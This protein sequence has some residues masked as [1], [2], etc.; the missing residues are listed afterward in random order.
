[1]AKKMTEKDRINYKIERI[2][3]EMS[4]DELNNLYEQFSS[5]DDYVNY[6]V[7]NIE[8]THERYLITIMNDEMKS[9]IK[10]SQEDT[11]YGFMPVKDALE[12]ITTYIDEGKCNGK[13]KAVMQNGYSKKSVDKYKEL[14]EQEAREGKVVTEFTKPS[15]DDIMDNIYMNDY[16][17]TTYHNKD[18]DLPDELRED[19]GVIIPGLIENKEEYFEF[20]RRLKDRGKE[21]LG[22][23]IYNKY[24]DYEEAVELIEQ[25]K[26][27][28]FDKYGGKEEFFQAKELGGM[29]GAYEYYP[30]VKPRFKKTA[31][32]IK[33]DKGI[34]LNSLAL[35][36]DMGRRIREEYEEEINQ[37]EVDHEYVIYENT[38]P[39]FKDL[40][41]ELQ[42]FYKTDKYGI[43]GFTH[44]NK[45]KSLYEYAHELTR[46]DDPE[47][48]AEG[49]RIID[50][51]EREEYANLDTYKSEFVDIVDVDELSTFAALSQFQYDKL[52]KEHKYKM[53][54]VD[55]LVDTIEVEKGY[56][57]FAK[58]QIQLI[59][60]QKEESY[61]TDNDL[62]EKVEHARRYIFDERYR[63][64][65]DELDKLN[66]AGDILIEKEKHEKKAKGEHTFGSGRKEGDSLI[67]HYVNELIKSTSST[68]NA[69]YSNADNVN[70]TTSYVDT[71]ECGYGSLSIDGSMLDLE[72]TPEQLLKYMK[73]NELLAKRVY[74]EGSDKKVGQTFSE[75]TN[76][77]DFINE[78]KESTK[79]MITEEL[80]K[81]GLENKR[82]GGR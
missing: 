73:N 82:K 68:I 54:V 33:L 1:M 7:D 76:I 15:F 27:A 6:H 29:F 2:R 4:R 60:D 62:K 81:E 58:N 49:Y 12:F 64:K 66:R 79:P 10:D 67:K 63:N 11:H 23:T 35:V 26:Q 36:T 8:D 18:E 59:E 44:T 65:Q 77:D 17:G 13:R 72:A 61:M 41:E 45:F 42:M 14:V 56:M 31:R 69:M 52:M 78:V 38:P 80:I 3:T 71:H 39:K 16:N 22:R 30:T 5:D 9:P 74:E 51:I 46:T 40:P 57:T 70:T 34:N 20:V 75:R 32:N 55:S 47:Q 28:L 19:V 25:Y 53:D 43:N 24:E 50:M 48:Q 21:G 37:Y